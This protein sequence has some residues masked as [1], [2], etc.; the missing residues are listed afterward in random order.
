MSLTGFEPGY[1]VRAAGRDNI[2]RYQLRLVAA[3]PS[4]PS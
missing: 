2:K 3:A 1:T 4:I